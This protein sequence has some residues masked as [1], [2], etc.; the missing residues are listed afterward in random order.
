MVTFLAR[1]A[2]TARTRTTHR[3]TSYGP[4]RPFIVSYCRRPHGRRYPTLRGPDRRETAP[5]KAVECH[6]SWF[7]AVFSARRSPI[8]A[9]FFPACRPAN[10]TFLRSW[11][12]GTRM[13][14]REDTGFSVKQP[15]LHAKPGRSIL[16]HPKTR[17][18]VT[19]GC[20]WPRANCPTIDPVLLLTAECARQ[21]ASKPPQNP[22]SCNH[23]VSM[24]QG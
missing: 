15:V 21:A 14:G 18:A 22:S 9:A 23:R 7:L 2:F 17:R 20:L 1:S 6:F 10:I 24:A 8:A 11:N 5:K 4:F 19:T 12:C 13:R 16:S 3:P